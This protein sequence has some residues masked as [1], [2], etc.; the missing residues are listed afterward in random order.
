MLQAPMHPAG[1]ITAHGQAPLTHPPVVPAHDLQS[2]YS[3]S[4]VCVL[5]A[6]HTFVSDVA[7][8]PRTLHSPSTLCCSHDSSTCA[9]HEKVHRGVRQGGCPITHPPS[10]L[11]M[12][13][14][15]KHV[16]ACCCPQ[17]SAAACTYLRMSPKEAS[18]GSA[19]TVNAAGQTH[20][21][22][23]PSPPAESKSRRWR[24]AFAL[25]K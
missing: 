17:A 22:V 8:H 19:T 20:L 1:T 12:M 4:V 10:Y 9:M 21:V 7:G 16:R 13:A 11:V 6:P 2:N 3:T 25:V 5:L 24:V 14:V 18:I 23:P 15:S